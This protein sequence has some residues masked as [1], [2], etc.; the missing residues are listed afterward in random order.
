MQNEYLI[1]EGLQQKADGQATFT[2]TLN[3]I[4]EKDITENV[5]DIKTSTGIFSKETGIVVVSGAKGGSGCSFIS[6]AIAA[7][8]ARFKSKNVVL[9]DLNS[10]KKDTRIIFNIKDE[11]VRDLGDV[12]C[13]F[14]DIDLSILKKL[15]INTE[16]SLNIILPPLKF[17]KMELL[18]PENVHGLLDALMRVFDLIIID[19]P[20]HLLQLKGFDFLEYSDKFFLVSQADY[21]SISNLEVLFNNLFLENSPS[22]VEIVIN[23]YNVKPVISPA[24]IMNMLRF[25]VSAFIPYD[26]DIEFLYLTKGP[27]P[28]FNYNL[29]I[30]KVISD[31]A[32]N[33]Y[34]SLFQ[35]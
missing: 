24:R 13:S 8:F 34:S 35:E 29:R 9:L 15:V 3:P 7:C 1:N 21:I 10:G 20:Y 25:P 28:M 31:F 5:R 26:S 4:V 32:E 17:E 2:R 14:K 11:I 23:K 16:S 19:F 18:Q 6:N 33:I 22:R 12:A 27:F 30:V